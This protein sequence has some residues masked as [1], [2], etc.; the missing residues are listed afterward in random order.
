MKGSCMFLQ[1]G[2]GNR[3]LVFLYRS[4][5]YIF[6]LVYHANTVCM[7][8]NP[9]AVGLRSGTCLAQVSELVFA[10]VRSRPRAAGVLGKAERGED[11][12]AG[13]LSGWDGSEAEGS[14][15]YKGGREA[16]K[17]RPADLSVSVP[18]SP[19]PR[20]PTRGPCQSAQVSLLDLHGAET[21]MHQGGDGAT[22][23]HSWS[24]QHR[25]ATTGRGL[26]QAPTQ[27]PHLRLREAPFP[28]GLFCF[29]SLGKSGRGRGVR[30]CLLNIGNRG[31]E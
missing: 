3:K 11:L 7:N 30:R 4:K 1:G 13:S 14:R 25:G 17:P 26:G 8:I 21:S 29:V 22:R 23:S 27:L 6:L 24:K 12:L 10:P 9:S 15:W 20:G 2:G 19:F 18:R 5:K 28:D 16:A 31:L